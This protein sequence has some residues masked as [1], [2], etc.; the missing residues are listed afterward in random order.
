[1]LVPVADVESPVSRLVKAVWR[2]MLAAERDPVQ[3][4]FTLLDDAVRLALPGPDG[5]QLLLRVPLTVVAVLDL[6]LVARAYVEG[7]VRKPS[8]EDAP[9]LTPEAGRTPPRAP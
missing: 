7:W 5:R 1:M 3:L 2:E 4:G 8:R 9:R 6:D